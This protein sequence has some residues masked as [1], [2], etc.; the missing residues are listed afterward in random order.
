[1][2]FSY[3]WLKE[4]TGLKDSPE[5][6]AEFLTL[7]AFEVERVEK[8]GHD[9]ALDISGKTIGPR[10]ADASGHLGMAREIA[11][12]KELR[13]KND[14]LRI[15][16][17]TKRKTSDFLE[18][19]IENLDDCSRYTARVIMGAKIAPSP[20]WLEERLAA[21]GIQPINNAVDAA[22]YIMLETGQPLHV[23]DADK[24]SG[25]DKKTIIIRRARAGERLAALDGITYELNPDIL[26]IADSERA[27]AIA[28]I[29]GGA[30]SGIGE[31][32]SAI[33]IEA[34][35]FHPARIRMASQKL[36]LRTDASLRF[37]HGLDPNS[38]INAADRLAAL[39]Q[40]IAGGTIAGGYTDYYPRKLKPA[41][42][43]FRTDYA[44]RLIG[45]NETPAAYRQIFQTLGWSVKAM[46]KNTL[47]IMPPTARM[48]I[49]IE[50]DL[51]EEAARI[52]GYD[53]I[54]A[55]PPAV[56]LSPVPRNDELFWESRIQDA[57]VGLGF[58]ES[59]LSAFTG[60]HEMELF[61]MTGAE[62]VSLQNPANPESTTL[63]PRAAIRYI[64]STAENLRHAERVMFFGIA[65]SFIKKQTPAGTTVDEKKHLI[66]TLAQKGTTGI[67]EFY[68]LKGA[69]D[70]S[71]ETLGIDE[72]AY[73]T[74]QAGKPKAKREVKYSALFHPHR[75]AEIVINGTYVG[76]LGEVASVISDRLKARARIIAAELDF[77]TLWS[78]ARDSV[79]FCPIGKFPA[80]MRDIAI[81]VPANTLA[82][83]V[84]NILENIGGALLIDTDMFDYFQDDEMSTAE[85]KSL[86]F[87]LIFQSPERTLTEREVDALLQ[88]I[89][90]ALEEQDWEIRK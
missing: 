1:M 2:R 88:K 32:T 60:P 46:K 80:V 11:A 55:K 18:V 8:S 63:V 62:A 67:D 66:L 36:K 59:I 6:L 15:S 77:N 89:T 12:L 84:Q 49:R 14:T 87:H 53:H 4:L 90:A 45:I 57:L 26:V 17:D 30:D 33:I 13:M 83:T 16:E 39:I 47:T 78:A 79:E 64:A 20:A 58:T 51:I 5:E 76:I 86:A 85:M 19:R 50:E 34:A 27:L 54:L 40:R 52:I 10:M 81:L 73:R 65:K 56:A 24:I 37:E 61:G 41:A 29:K 9:W 31:T 48:D 21:C 7:R 3:N 35:N 69:L 22:H 68:Q 25:T 72:H 75:V 43:P 38:T 74:P 42:I 44:N 28:G 71:L 70:Q 82:E 23:F